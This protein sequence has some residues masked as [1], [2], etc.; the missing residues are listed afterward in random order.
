[1]E[2]KK[3]LVNDHV[4]YNGYAHIIESIDDDNVM[5]SEMNARGVYPAFSV[6]G[7]EVEIMTDEEACDADS[8]IASKWW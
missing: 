5:I 7:S 3:L 6:K 2:A 4:W 1:M 8:Y